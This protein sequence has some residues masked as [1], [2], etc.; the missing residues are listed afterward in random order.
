VG[1]GDAEWS[2]EALVELEFA[3]RRGGEV[4][5]L[6]E[7]LPKRL[8][9]RLEVVQFA[10]QGGDFLFQLADAGGRR[11]R[12]G[13]APKAESSRAVEISPPSSWP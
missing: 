5:W 13:G 9:L 2:D 6:L 12:S 8:E 7:L 4:R 3:N 1:L 10:A 11:C